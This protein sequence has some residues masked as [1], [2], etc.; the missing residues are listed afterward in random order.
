MKNSPDFHGKGH[1]VWEPFLSRRKHRQPKFGRSVNWSSPKLFR[2]PFLE[3][4]G[5]VG[6]VICSSKSS[7]YWPWPVIVSIPGYPDV[8]VQLSPLR[9]IRSWDIPT[10]GSLERF[11]MAKARWIDELR[12]TREDWKRRPLSFKASRFNDDIQCISYVIG[13]IWD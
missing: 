4:M 12:A 2:A 7:R 1:F 3:N 13:G 8:Y 11:N 5:T 9:Y 10:R 6:E